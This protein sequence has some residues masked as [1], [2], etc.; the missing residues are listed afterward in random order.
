VTFFVHIRNVHKTEIHESDLP[1]EQI[2]DCESKICRKL[3]GFNHQQL[4]CKECVLNPPKT[5]SKGIKRIHD[6]SES[7]KV[8]VNKLG[9]DNDSLFQFFK[10]Y[11]QE[12]ETFPF[13]Y[14][15]CNFSGPRRDNLFLHL[16]IT[17]LDEMRPKIENFDESKHVKIPDC[18]NKICKKLFGLNR[19]HLFCEKCT[20]KE[21]K[22]YWQKRTLCTLIVWTKCS[23]NCNERTYD[24]CTQ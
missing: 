23:N 8:R 22:K 12:K 21:P 15:F 13:E 11:N 20:D 2:E 17:H 5:K 18:G 9:I 14:S 10:P 24:C 1:P 3:Y 4:W 6:V 16:K 19:P 7:S